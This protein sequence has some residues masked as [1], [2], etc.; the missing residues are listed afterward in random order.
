M[1]MLPRM[2]GSTREPARADEYLPGPGSATGDSTSAKSDSV[3]WPSGRAANVI[4]R[5]TMTRP[6][7]SALFTE[8]GSEAT[9]S[10]RVT[11]CSADL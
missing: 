10:A 1:L 3:G 11:N 8:P 6:S 2:Y 5:F 9:L 4:C 7:H